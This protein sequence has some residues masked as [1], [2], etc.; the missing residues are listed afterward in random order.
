MRND[1]ISPLRGC[2]DSTTTEV[3]VEG[4]L[5][6]SFLGITERAERKTRAGAITLTANR[7]SGSGAGLNVIA[8]PTW[9]IFVTDGLKLKALRSLTHTALLADG[10]VVVRRQEDGLEGKDGLTYELGGFSRDTRRR[11]TSDGQVKRTPNTV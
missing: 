8:A 11:A 9:D 5:E 4:W 7:A 6:D 3:I 10:V 1:S 2:W